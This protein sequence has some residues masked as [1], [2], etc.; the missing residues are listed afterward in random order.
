MEKS[1]EDGVDLIGYTIWSAIDI[2]SASTGEYKK[3]F[4]IIYV[5]RYD[6]GTGNFKRYKKDIFYWYR[7][8]IERN[9]LEN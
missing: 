5:D 1:I 8:L 6:D 2:V 3:R 4:G 9:G 7:D